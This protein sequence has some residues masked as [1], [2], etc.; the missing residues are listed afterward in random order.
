MTPMSNPMKFSCSAVLAKSIRLSADTFEHQYLAPEIATVGLPGQFVH[1]RVSDAT[2]PLLRRPISIL[3]CNPQTGI[4]RVLFKV[5]REGTSLLASRREGDTVEIVGPLGRPFPWDEQRDA[6]MIA[7]GYG[8]SPVLF[9]ARC[10]RESG[11]KCTIIYGARTHGD[12]LLVDE[13]QNT[14][15]ESIFTTNDG[16]FG[17]QG[18]INIPLARLLQTAPDVAVYACGPTPMLRAVAEISLAA[19]ADI[20]CWVS[21]ENRMGCG[22]GVC[23]GCV[24][25]ATDGKMRTVCKDGP[26]FD[27]REID[28]DA[29][30]KG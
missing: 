11:R 14:F 27:A 18:M 21:M 9:L 12:L 28:F 2:A 29:N 8:V 1:I 3:D 23:G 20:P 4:A 5:V 25:T 10:H 16:S 7:G 30:M 17:E 26:V 6:V 24:V 13:I 22:V 19:N 15:H